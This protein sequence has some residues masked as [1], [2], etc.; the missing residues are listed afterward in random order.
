MPNE[1]DY[2]GKHLLAGL[3]Y[4]DAAGEIVR[5]LQVHGV[6]TRITE[7]AIFFEQISGEEFSLPADLE[8]LKPAPP[9]D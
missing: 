5:R 6:I 3:T 8:S 4:V 1:H 7:A 2:I 9:G